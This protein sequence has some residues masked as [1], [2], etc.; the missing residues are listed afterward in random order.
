MK[1]RISLDLTQ[2]NNFS[3]IKALAE[4]SEEGRYTRLITS[5]AKPFYQ[6]VHV[7]DAGLSI[8]FVFAEAY[9]VLGFLNRF[10]SFG[11]KTFTAGFLDILKIFILLNKIFY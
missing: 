6:T 2:K 8:N 10:C 11:I 3:Y 1:S 5:P 4:E 7:D 9:V